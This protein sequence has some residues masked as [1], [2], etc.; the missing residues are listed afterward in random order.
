MRAKGLFYSGLLY[1]MAIRVISYYNYIKNNTVYVYSI[2][3]YTCTL[4]RDL[5]RH[6]H[7]CPNCHALPFALSLW[8]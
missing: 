5:K 6:C 3:V 2:A 7:D 4:W 8:Q 1:C